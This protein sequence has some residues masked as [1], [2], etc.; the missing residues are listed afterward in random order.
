MDGPAIRH[1]T[2]NVRLTSGDLLVR[3]CEPGALAGL[4]TLVGACHAEESELSG[5]ADVGYGVVF[6]AVAGDLA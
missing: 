1:Q 6:R 4:V 2:L 3:E 5:V